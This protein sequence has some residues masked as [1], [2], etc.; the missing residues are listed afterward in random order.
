MKRNI[1]IVLTSVIFSVAAVYLIELYGV[2][3]S[4][5][6]L[7]PTGYVEFA[8]WTLAGLTA[9]VATFF[10]TKRDKKELI[11]LPSSIYLSFLAVYFL[12]HG[13][14]LH[15]DCGFG[16]PDG[17]SFINIYSVHIALITFFI[18]F[19]SLAAAILKCKKK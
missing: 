5:R 17:C 3:L 10:I 4:S 14:Y 19:P 2:M 11:L 8:G 7:P 15:F 13:S 16:G 1:L 12:K 9:F 6:E 18:L